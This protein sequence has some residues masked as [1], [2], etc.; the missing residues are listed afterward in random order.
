M[1]SFM[2]SRRKSNASAAQNGKSKPASSSLP[3]IDYPR[4]GDVLSPVHYAVRISPGPSQGVA[5]SIDD[6][7]WQPCRPAAGHYW[8]DW[9]KPSKGAHILIVRSQTP[10]GRF[11]KSDRRNCKVL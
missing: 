4:E 8:F 5:I 2:L 6:G 7:S 10:G 11:L 1:S 9:V 3:V